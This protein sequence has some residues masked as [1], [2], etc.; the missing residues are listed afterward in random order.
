MP[1]DSNDYVVQ[2]A[3]LT[4]VFRDF[5]HRAK[6]RALNELSLQIHRGEVYGLLG[7]NGAG[8]ST[9]VKLL[10]GLLFPTSGAIRIFGRLP[11]DIR[12]KARL[13]FL[14]EETYLY[15]YL[16]ARETLD[17]FGRLNR[18]PR[19]ERQR[20]VDALIDMVGL[21]GARNRPIREYSKGMTR[22]IGIA[23]ALINDPELILLD[24]PTT[25]LDPIGTREVKDLIV[26]LKERGKTILLCSHLLA[27]VQDVCDR[28]GVLYGGQLCAEGPVNELLAKRHVT[29]FTVPDLSVA[30]SGRVE[31]MVREVAGNRSVEVGHPHDRL[32]DFFLR[33]VREARQER[34]ETSGAAEGRFDSSLFAT[35][36]QG[37]V[38]ERLTASAETE[39]AE[40]EAVGEAPAEEPEP[41]ERVLAG[42]TAAAEADPAPQVEAEAAV[43]AQAAQAG[44]RRAVLGRLVADDDKDTQ[45]KAPPS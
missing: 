43:D 38:I 28:I 37:G 3:R 12:V 16:N 36:G 22:R 25:G 1:H 23:Q 39:E 18:L 14:P 2:T 40:A 41:G 26:Q 30:E 31:A 8:K 20:R 33:V 6:V 13:G 4:K 42:L 32:E 5:W 27:D 9:C 10:L 35:T 24:E 11:R 15:P 17:F 19:A 45:D 7:P 34:P 29:Q 21:T 44:Q